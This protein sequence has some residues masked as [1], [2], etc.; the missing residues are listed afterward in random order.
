MDGESPNDR[1]VN[2]IWY[3][4]ALDFVQHP[5]QKIIIVFVSPETYSNNYLKERRI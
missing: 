1:I 3:L 5:M 2:N 4:T